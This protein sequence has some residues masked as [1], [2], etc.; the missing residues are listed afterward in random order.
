MCRRVGF[1]LLSDLNNVSFRAAGL[2]LC[3]RR[4]AHIAFMLYQPARIPVQAFLVKIWK[5]VK[6]NTRYCSYTEWASVTSLYATGDV[7][8]KP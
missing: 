3:Y 6:R 8:P 4:A 1:I 2:R 5:A 7:S